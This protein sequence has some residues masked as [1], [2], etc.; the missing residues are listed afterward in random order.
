MSVDRAVG[1]PDYSA[2]GVIP[3][4]F[5][6]EFNIK[7][8]MQTIM[9]R[10]TNTKFIKELLKRG[11]TMTVPLLPDITIRPAV[12]GQDMEEQVPVPT[13][14]TITMSRACYYNVSLSDVDMKQSG[15]SLKKEFADEA[16]LAAEEYTER[17]FFDA[18]KTEA[19]PAN[20]GNNAGVIS[21]AYVLGSTTTALAIT[22]S[23][24]LKA[25][26]SFRR[27]FG[28]QNAR[29]GKKTWA[30][31]PEW[32]AGV[33]DNSDLKNASFVGSGESTLLSGD[34]I[35]MLRGIA[36]YS[37]NAL[38]T[39]TV[40]SNLCHY[41]I[42]GNSDAVCY[43]AQLNESRIINPEKRF[44]ALVQGL[45]VYDWKVIKPEGL[46]VMVAYAG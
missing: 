2:A 4:L 42:A 36:L 6:D 39:V 9:P 35:G 25:L 10:I 21:G 40:G 20:M 26:M 46:A 16:V 41:I 31:I 37:S 23:N 15:I 38:P 18:I 5:A 14:I 17:E 30:V 8:H 11:D 27:V 33:L 19:H 7:Y 34:D 24:V 22:P 28:E 32:M 44:G 43:G 45:Q 1:Y 29:N 3:Q 13:N 12:V